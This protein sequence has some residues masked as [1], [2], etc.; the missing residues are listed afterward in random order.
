MKK[1]SVILGLCA[2]IAVSCSERD[3]NTPQRPPQTDKVEVILP[4][5]DTFVDTS[6]Q[7][8]V[9]DQL[10]MTRTYIL[11][12]GKLDKV[13][14]SETDL[15]TLWAT[16][17]AGAN[18]TLYAEAFRYYS[19]VQGNALFT[20]TI[21]EMAEGTYTYYGCY[22]S[23]DTFTGTQVTYTL[24]TT[25]NGVYDGSLDI[26]LAH[27]ASGSN[28]TADT[29]P[30]AAQLAFAH[31]CHVMRIQVPTGRNL[32]GVGAKKLRIKFPTE[33]VGKLTFDVA[34]PNA[35]PTFTEGS[36]TVILDLKRPLDE[37]AE[38]SG[39]GNYVWV[40]LRPGVVIDGALEFTAYSA[41]GYQSET[42]STHVSRT[43]AAGKITP[44][45]IS[46]PQELPL[47][48]FDFSI[49][50][51]N[52][53]ED[54][55]KLHITLPEGATLRNGGTTQSFDIDASNKYTVGFYTT[56][57]GRN[58][59]ELMRTAATTISYES[60]NALV[61]EKRVLGSYTP[62]EHTALSLSAPYLLAEDFSGLTSDVSDNESATGI[63]DPAAIWL[64]AYG[65]PHWSASRVGGKAG[66]CIR[67]SGHLEGGIGASAYY[68]GR[69]DSPPL[70]GIKP[71]KSVKLAISFNYSADNSDKVPTCQYGWSVNTGAINGSP[72]IEN[73]IGVISM[74]KN[75]G[76]SYTTVPL[77]FS[78]DIAS[79]TSATRL[80]WRVS[81]TDG[82][83]W[84][85]SWHC[86]V[87][88]DNI[89]VKI[90]K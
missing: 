84:G 24:S 16:P 61:P 69:M 4:V 7:D 81:T 3:D 21:P 60:E 75:L 88:F 80:S 53:G 64:D 77:F 10:P 85:G 55:Y 45:T 43:L 48:F 50:G 72:G 26:M 29:S 46:I 56:V 22:P 30:N 23:P 47:S 87:Y 74:A 70:S 78:Y 15:V 36:N 37:S 19:P 54:I 17:D 76:G 6:V 12:D 1:S 25:Q 82:V 18:Y 90:V 51:N 28:L 8:A 14:W 20:A 66:L 5:A 40:F 62:L 49:N 73:Q 67:V 83:G 32:W 9:S 38:G 86:R 2:L 33:V 79:A 11:G 57:D 89:K 59:G 71:G 27:P 52:L 31:K 44:V 35:E 68:E 63:Y 42:I 65:V 41:E 58:I 39:D 34:D 13:G